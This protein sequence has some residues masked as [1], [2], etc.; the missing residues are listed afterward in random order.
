MLLDA[1]NDRVA[2]A[3]GTWPDR[4]YLVSRDGRVAWQDAPEPAGFQP[5][6]LESAIRTE[7]GGA[8]V[9][10]TPPIVETTVSK[11]GTRIGWGR[12]G[13]GPPLLLVHGTTADRTRW[14][15][16][17]PSLEEHS[18]VY[19]VDR[20]G[21]G[22]SGDAAS[23]AIE[24]EY[25]DVAAVVDAIGR[26]VNL[27]GHSY[28]GRCS[29]G[30]ALLTPNLRRLILYEPALTGDVYPPGFLER[31][32]ECLEAGDRE[33]VLTTFFREVVRVP[34]DELTLLQSSPAWQGRIKAAHTIVREIR[35]AKHHRVQPDRLKDFSTPTLLLLGGDSPPPFRAAIDELHDA[36]P[37]SRIAVL[38]GQRH[39][40]MDTGPEI[41][42]T[43]VIGFLSV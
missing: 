30:A 13:L 29:L 36:L 43:E 40:A 35:A 19:A 22:A 8:C 24:R 3:C 41:F 15:P 7:L 34:P 21:R 26:P 4:L 31:L 10:I 37:N 42:T 18:T 2:R 33:K 27:L 39:A 17:L 32:Q 20:R 14:Q 9:A 23:Y 1:L 25:E 11:D 38:P 28:G 16:V 6:E 12:S 5:D